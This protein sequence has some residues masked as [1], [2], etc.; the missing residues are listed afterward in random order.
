MEVV[1]G[2]R[3]R[4]TTEKLTIKVQLLMTSIPL[5]VEYITIKLKRLNLIWLPSPFSC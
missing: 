4:D 3:I 5:E 2:R 1:L